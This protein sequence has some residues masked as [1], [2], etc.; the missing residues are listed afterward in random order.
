MVVV[1]GQH[2]WD[3]ARNEARRPMSC[4]W[5]RPGA[6]MLKLKSHLAGQGCPFQPLCMSRAACKAA[7]GPAGACPW[8]CTDSCSMH[9]C[10]PTA[11]L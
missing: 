4:N 5:Q 1:G 10:M 6:C 11:R 3:V 7:Q 9:A 2:A 8:L